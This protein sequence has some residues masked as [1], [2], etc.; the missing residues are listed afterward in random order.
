MNKL[1]SPKLVF[2][3]NLDSDW[4]VDRPWTTRGTHIMERGKYILAHGKTIV[5]R[6]QGCLRLPPKTY[7]FSF[8]SLWITGRQNCQ[9]SERFLKDS[10]SFFDNAYEAHN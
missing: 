1:A 6:G 8:A 9:R 10:R 2:L 5:A 3:I 7:E 4:T